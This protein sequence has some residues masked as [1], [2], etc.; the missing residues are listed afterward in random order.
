MARITIPFLPI[1]T[2]Q[3]LGHFQFRI[4]SGK[5]RLPSNRLS[6]TSST[7]QD[8]Y[9]YVMN[10]QT[11]TRQTL[12]TVP[13]NN[14]DLASGTYTLLIQKNKYKDYRENFTIEDGKFT[15]VNPILEENNSGVNVQEPVVNP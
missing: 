14:K 7:A 15:I 4:S 2:I 6:I 12:G 8:A 3:N 9:V 1:D 11:G 10:T 13:V 5:R